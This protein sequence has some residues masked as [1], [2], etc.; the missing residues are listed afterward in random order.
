MKKEN[1]I[2]ITIIIAL[3]LI[4]CVLIALYFNGGTNSQGNMKE[5]GSSSQMGAPGQGGLG[6]PG[7]QNGGDNSESVEKTGATEF[8][9]E[10]S[11]SSQSY[12]ST[13][14][15]ESAILVKDGGKAKI[16]NSTVSKSSGDSSNVENSE[17]YGV[18]AGILVTSG[19]QATLDNLDI[20]TSAKGSNA[21]FSTGT[22]SKIYI[23]N[24]KIETAKDS[25]RGLDATYGGYI[26][27]DNV[28]ISTQGGSCATLAT[29]RGEG[30]VIAKNSTLSTAGSGSPVIYS[31]GD[32]TLENS[33]GKAT[34]AQMVVIEGKN[35]ATVTNST[36]ECSGKGNRNN[37]DNCGI[38]IYQSMSGDAG[39]GTGTLN[40]TNAT[41]S[42]SSNSDYYKTAPLFFITNTK[43]IINLEN[44]TLQYGSGI[45][46]KAQGTS[47]WGTS[48]N[49]GGEVT[50]NAKNQEL[51][52]NIEADNISTVEINLKENSNLNGAINTDNTA[53]EIKLSLDTTSTLTLTG[54]T[55][56]TELNDEDATYSNIN[57]NGY[58]LYVNGTAIEK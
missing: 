29:D 32:I 40:A 1:I 39:E 45:L 50:L 6:G 57:L 4:L 26:E 21:V 55:Y 37:V 34:G 8:S 23:S 36:L 41:L 54:D 11:E 24:S 43:A 48:E 58:K 51:T 7:G 56:V 49:N 42:I 18:N 30:T 46:L 20:S 27:A 9:E 16:S 10:K 52:G 15:D 33:T 12:E 31:T 3:I 25:S 22:D 47:E 53:K 38:M 2:Q 35:T 28:E 14:S 44:N 19:S 5:N 13:N 17:F